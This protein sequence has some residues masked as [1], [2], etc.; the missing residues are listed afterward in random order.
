MGISDNASAREYL[1]LS[2]RDLHGRLDAAAGVMRL[3]TYPGYG[4]FLA[5]H[6]AALTPLEA[7]LEKGGIDRLLPDWALRRRSAALAEDLADLGLS[8]EAM[9]A[10]TFRSEAGLLGAAYVLEGSRLGARVVL[11][12][13]SPESPTRYLSHGEGQ[14][15]W[16]NF[17]AVLE[18]SAEVRRAPNLAVAAARAAFALFISATPVRAMAIAS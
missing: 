13:V 15:F 1:K 3:E 11:G 10:P 9:A 8:C 14:R 7:A 12:R 4:D 17:L 2:T 16:P 5:A 6:A 18:G